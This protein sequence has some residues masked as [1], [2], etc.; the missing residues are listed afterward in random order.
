MSAPV[1][2]FQKAV[3]RKLSIKVDAK[4][5]TVAAA[6]IETALS[7]ALI[8]EKAI[9]PASERQI[10]YAN[11]LG[12]GTSKDSMKVASARIRDRLGE[13]NAERIR[14]LQLVPGMRVK[15]KKWNQ[16]MIISSISEN[17]LLWF[18]GGNG[19]CAFPSQVQAIDA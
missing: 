1:S 16:E 19:K 15:W 2:K 12:I 11:S 18:K 4:S 14:F 8:G 3:A 7:A 5:F 10:A 6:Q 13:T 17:G 9:K